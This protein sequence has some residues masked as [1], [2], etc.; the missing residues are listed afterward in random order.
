ME[1]LGPSGFTLLILTLVEHTI[2]IFDGVAVLV[3]IGVSTW[4]ELKDMLN[5]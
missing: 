3:Y 1:A 5:E 4:R 2:L